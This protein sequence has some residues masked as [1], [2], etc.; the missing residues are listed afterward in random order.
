MLFTTCFGK[1]VIKALFTNDMA[2]VYS[3]SIKKTGGNV[4]HYQADS[5]SHFPRPN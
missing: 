3:L 4:M 1:L 2:A 5:L